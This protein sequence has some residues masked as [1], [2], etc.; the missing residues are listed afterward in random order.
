MLPNRT[1]PIFMT[2][3]I[4]YIYMMPLQKQK[5]KGLAEAFPESGLQIG[6]WLSG[7]QG[8][9]YIVSGVLDDEIYRLFDFVQDR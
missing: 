1:V 8:C 4:I 9:R 6:L 5:Q 2:R 7:G 3:I